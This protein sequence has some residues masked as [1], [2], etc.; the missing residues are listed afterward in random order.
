MMAHAAVQTATASAFFSLALSL[1]LNPPGELAVLHAEHSDQSSASHL[2][3][4]HE[5]IAPNGHA[6]EE[7]W[8]RPPAIDRDALESNETRRM[9][10]EWKQK[11]MKL[12]DAT[13]AFKRASQKLSDGVQATNR[14]RRSLPDEVARLHNVE[15]ARIAS[16]KAM[17]AAE[18]ERLRQARA[19]MA[20]RT[21]A[22]LSSALGSDVSSGMVADVFM[23]L[24]EALQDTTFANATAKAANN[25]Q[26][27][28]ANFSAIMERR[29]E[30]FTQI[31]VSQSDVR[32]AHEMTNFI[33]DSVSRL[34]ALHA[35]TK[36]ELAK[37]GRA[38]PASLRR[39]LIPLLD[40]MLEALPRM[41]TSASELV[42]GS[43]GD[44]CGTV[45]GLMENI[46]EYDSK[47]AWTR[48]FLHNATEDMLPAMRKVLGSNI[49][50][51]GFESANRSDWTA[52]CNGTNDYNTTT[53]T[54]HT[55]SYSLKVPDGGSKCFHV[56][57]SP[58]QFITNAGIPLRVEVWAKGSSANRSSRKVR[59]G[60]SRSALHT[61][62]DSDDA[63]M[64]IVPA[65]KWTFYS[66]ESTPSEDVSN[67]VLSICALAGETLY[68]DDLTVCQT[69][70]GSCASPEVM[71]ISRDVSFF[72]TDI[73]KVATLEVQALQEAAHDIVD[74]VGP[75]VTERVHC[76]W[77]A[78]QAPHG[79]GPLAAAASVAAAYLAAL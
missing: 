67:Q 17:I 23:A 78:A 10:T 5:N 22:A 11:H 66:F 44:A 16:E 63:R 60:L 71:P 31:S 74:Q 53:E 6:T 64:W 69:T 27:F 72:M 51:I 50:S 2:A 55:G 40:V 7:N 39:D 52:H 30:V 13:E 68:I 49:Y 59:F 38:M 61:T 65:L 37:L 20:Q 4:F 70:T 8:E 15:L 33:R 25:M 36:V 24:P 43:L 45:S 34:R 18:E 19:A 56:G 79:L 73:A 14:A 21:D 77:A 35:H 47:M 3:V 76:A 46:G 26:A 58:S 29:L 12:Q 62:A 9:T 41:A 75:I 28:I 48:E 1:T 57:T 32:L 42:E 54:A